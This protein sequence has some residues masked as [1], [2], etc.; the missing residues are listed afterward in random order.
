MQFRGTPIRVTL[1]HD[2]LTLA[3]HPEGG[4][5]P[6]KV[7]VADEVRQ[8]CPGDSTA[9]DLGRKATTSAAQAHE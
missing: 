2:R 3:V 9:F 4:S 8:L 1:S 6:I 5:L 7:A